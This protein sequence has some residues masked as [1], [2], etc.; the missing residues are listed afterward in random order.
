MA[1]VTALGKWKATGL[2]ENGQAQ[3]PEFGHQHPQ[4]H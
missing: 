3:E 1:G 2:G 4:H